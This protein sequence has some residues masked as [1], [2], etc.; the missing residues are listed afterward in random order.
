[1]HYVTVSIV[2]NTLGRMEYSPTIEEAVIRAARIVRNWD[3]YIA[4]HP[5]DI[6]KLLI[7]N[8]MFHN[9]DPNTGI[10]YSVYIGI[11]E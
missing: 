2:N 6:E 7:N 10:L 8:H 3:Q 11:A 1:M 5:V 9:C 4:R